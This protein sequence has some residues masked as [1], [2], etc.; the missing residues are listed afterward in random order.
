LLSWWVYLLIFID[1]NLILKQVLLT[2]K[3]SHSLSDVYKIY[4]LKPPRGKQL[5]GQDKNCVH[6][7]LFCR[8]F[9][10]FG[11]V[12]VYFVGP[13]W[14]KLGKIWQNRQRFCTDFVSC[15]PPGNLLPLG[16]VV[17]IKIDD[18]LSQDHHIRNK[19]P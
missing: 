6:L 15:F 3:N 16:Q 1:G 17:D 8:A 14:T 13:N 12:F 9:V 4:I 11:R 10:H 2:L 5:T 18:Q 7:V 19:Y